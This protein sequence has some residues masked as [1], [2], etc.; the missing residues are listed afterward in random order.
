MF[1][2]ILQ[3]ATLDSG[4]C[5][6]RFGAVTRLLCV[7]KLRSRG[8]LSPQALIHGCAAGGLRAPGQGVALLGDGQGAEHGIPGVG[9]AQCGDGSV[10]VA[11]TGWRIP[12]A[13]GRLCDHQLHHGPRRQQTWRWGSH[14]GQHASASMASGANFGAMT[15][16]LNI[17]CLQFL[18]RGGQM[19]IRKSS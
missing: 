12:A 11:H 14:P 17:Y 10:Y 2:A 3:V 13:G 8:V 19:K 7:G 15:M 1:R 6:Q 9:G 18:S 5:S 16:A 4:S